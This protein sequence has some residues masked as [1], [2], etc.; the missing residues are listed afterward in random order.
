MRLTKI[1]HK[2]YSQNETQ[3]K[4]FR[5]S[6]SQNET[7]KNISEQIIHKMRLTKMFYKNNSQN[8]T[9]KNVPQKGYTK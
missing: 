7:H 1:L 9:N 3:K 4:Y 6:I 2:N 5:T 8:K